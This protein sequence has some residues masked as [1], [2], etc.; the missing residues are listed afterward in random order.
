METT[1]KAVEIPQERCRRTGSSAD[2]AQLKG[3]RSWG[4]LM[5]NETSNSKEHVLKSRKRTLRICKGLAQGHLCVCDGTLD[6]EEGR[7]N[8]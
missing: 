1:K 4:N 3:A 8:T 2:V 5:Q 6:R 7:R